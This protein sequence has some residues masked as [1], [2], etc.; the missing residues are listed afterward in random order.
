MRVFI[1]I[2]SLLLLRSEGFAYERITHVYEAVVPLV[3]RSDAVRNEAIKKGL[4]Q[5]LIRY[6]GYAAIAGIVAVADELNSAQKY[7]IEYGVDTVEIES[8]DGLGTEK[9][10]ALWV[11]FNSNL[12]DQLA[13]GL[14]LPIW[15]TLRPTV[16]YAVVMDLWGKPHILAAGEYP[17]LSLHLSRIF[18]ERGLAAKQISQELL[19]AGIQASDLWDI[20]QKIADGL[21]RLSTADITMLVRLHARESQGQKLDFLFFESDAETVIH[22]TAEDLIS[23]LDEGINQYVDELSTGLAFLGGGDVELGLYVQILGMR[24]YR[25]YKKILNQIAGLEQVLSVRMEN[26]TDES[27][28]Y[29]ILYQSNRAL[30]IESITEITGIKQIP[31]I[32]EQSRQAIA[33]DSGGSAESPV[34]FRYPNP[35]FIVA[36]VDRPE[37]PKRRPPGVPG[38]A[39]APGGQQG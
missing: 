30:L 4:E 12:I 17:A 22:E 28:G 10:D 16:S 23:G 19:L 1:A 9:G 38:Q 25:E 15:P 31:A 14:E 21:K 8:Q 32:A 7:V 11:R 39:G 3:D 34:Y 6:T 37:D 20:D 27:I 2:L 24:S 13:R 18:N 29:L 26:A 33:G 35:T 5:V 36:P